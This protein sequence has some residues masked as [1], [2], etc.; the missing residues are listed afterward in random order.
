MPPVAPADD[1]PCAPRAPDVAAEGEA[2]CAPLVAEVLDVSV[3]V[4]AVRV[5]EIAVLP[6]RSFW[7]CMGR[8]SVR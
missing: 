5:L 2:G 1:A 3:D 6:E 4:S 7:I 8:G